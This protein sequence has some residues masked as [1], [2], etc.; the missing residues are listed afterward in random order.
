MTHATKSCNDSG[1]DRL[2]GRGYN[3]PLPRRAV[4]VN[5]FLTQYHVPI[6][7]DEFIVLNGG[8]VTR[9]SAKQIDGIWHVTFHMS[10]GSVMEIDPGQW[11]ENFVKNTLGVPTL[12]V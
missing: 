2:S 7:P 9:I 11:T 1:R 3:L 10:D 5:P 6:A 12:P 4:P 8:Q